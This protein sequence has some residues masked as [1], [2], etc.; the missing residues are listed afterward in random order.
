MT[1]S[2]PKSTT[3]KPRPIHAIMVVTTMDGAPATLVLDADAVGD[4][5]VSNYLRAGL[6]FGPLMGIRDLD[7]PRIQGSVE[8]IHNAI[9]HLLQRTA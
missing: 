3:S 6:G 2:S 4:K 9:E 7:K 5:V 8:H 1:A